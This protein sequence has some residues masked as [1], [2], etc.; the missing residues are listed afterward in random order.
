MATLSLALGVAT[1]SLALGVV[2]RAPPPRMRELGNM[3]KLLDARRSWS[4]ALTTAHVSA[5]VLSGTPPT[6]DELRAG[7]AWVFRRHPMLSQVVRGKG[8]HHIPGAQPYAPHDNY[9][10]RAF[11]EGE[12][13]FRPEGD[14]APPR[15]EPSPLDPEALAARALRVVRVDGG[16][17]AAAVDA[18]WRAGY[19]EALDGTQID[20]DGD[21]PMWSLTLYAAPS[22]PSSALLYAANHAISDQISQNRIL[23]EALH[24]AAELR[25]GRAVAPPEPLPLPPSVEG[26]L[27]GEPLPPLEPKQRAEVLIFGRTPLLG[28]EPLSS[29]TPP[30]RLS[31]IKY[32]LFQAGA[33]GGAVLP[34]GLAGDAAACSADEFDVR[35]RRSRSTFA[36][37][38][39]AATSALIKACKARGVTVS[40]AL[41]AASLFCATDV[42]VEPD[43]EKAA[44]ESGV[45]PEE[46]RLKLLQALDM[47]AFGAARDGGFFA[48]GAAP[49]GDWSE[50]TVVAGTGSLDVLIDLPPRS[51]EALLSGG[52]GG[53]GAEEESPLERFWRC[54]ASVTSGSR[55]WVADG[56][57]RESLLLFG[58]GWEFMNM[59]RVIEL[60]AQDVGTLGRAYAAAQFCREKS[61]QFSDALSTLSGTRAAT[62][63][64]ASSRTIWSTAT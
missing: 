10:K 36:T 4:G 56:Y 57:P 8:K 3:E 55:Q 49:G 53:G 32:G 9:L 46:M 38:T 43:K 39:P 48:D 60:G 26:A 24:V 25:A 14:P 45:P 62:R 31:S 64:S 35:R 58:A 44:A 5:T 1:L 51:G 12:E 17:D 29:R 11:E 30:V 63:T 19:E 50:G 37:L 54:A 40:G 61:A 42:L 22:A 52:G 6:E 28:D 33:G 16:D 23:T 7:L 20:P 59:N 13:L 41:G 18:A 2:P 34:R 47:R 21:G 15:F 27:V